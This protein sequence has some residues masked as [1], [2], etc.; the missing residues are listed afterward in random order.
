MVTGETKSSSV[1]VWTGEWIIPE[2]DHTGDSV[3]FFSSV[4][5]GS[6]VWD[7]VG[8]MEAYAYRLNPYGGHT[9]SRTPVLI[10]LDQARFHSPCVCLRLLCH[11]WGNGHQVGRCPCIRP[12]QSVHVSGQHPL[13]HPPWPGTPRM[14]STT[15]CTSG[16]FRSTFFPRSV[17]TFCRVTPE[18]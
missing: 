4:Y 11:P 10:T 6:R 12:A 7:R 3:I 16:G 15:C 8:C 2:S 18:N 13:I 1:K 9:Y 14:I 5:R 17:V